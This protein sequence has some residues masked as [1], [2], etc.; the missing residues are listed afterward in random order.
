MLTNLSKVKIKYMI[1]LFK[2][3]TRS[4]TNPLRQKM[5]IN[6]INLMMDSY[7]SKLWD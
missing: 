3:N 5:F 4:W 1:C 6:N 2:E 7:T